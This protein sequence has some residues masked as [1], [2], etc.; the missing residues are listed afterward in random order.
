VAGFDFGHTIPIFTFSIGGKAYLSAIDGQK[1]NLIL[2][3]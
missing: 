1:I 2:N 3:L